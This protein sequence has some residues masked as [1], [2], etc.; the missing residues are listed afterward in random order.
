MIRRYLAGLLLGLTATANA[1]DTASCYAIAAADARTYCL[2]PA[3]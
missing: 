1:S 3:A 2:A